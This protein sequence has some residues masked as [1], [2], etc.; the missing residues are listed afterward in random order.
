MILAKAFEMNHPHIDFWGHCMS[1]GPHWSDSS[2]ERAL[3][4]AGGFRIQRMR[5][6]PVPEAG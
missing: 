1:S 3:I 2:E 4:Q 6:S 5:R